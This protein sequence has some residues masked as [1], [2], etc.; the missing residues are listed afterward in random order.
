MWQW[1]R[2][3][4]KNPWLVK[5]NIIYQSQQHWKLV[6]TVRF[7]MVNTISEVSEAFDSINVSETGGLYMKLIHLT[8]IFNTDWY[9]RSPTRSLSQIVLLS[10]TI[11]N[12]IYQSPL[13][14]IW[15][16][17]YNLNKYL[18]IINVC[19]FTCSVV[20]SQHIIYLQQL[21]LIFSNCCTLCYTFT[22]TELKLP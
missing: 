8:L 22:K 9:L 10:W 14:V 5:G 20:Y 21:L 11:S 19:I 7:T 2:Q 17:F 13:F 1:G 4:L 6:L 15:F 12:Q 3:S 16:R 18:S